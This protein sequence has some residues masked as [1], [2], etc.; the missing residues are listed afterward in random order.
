MSFYAD[1]STNV[2]LPLLEPSNNAQY[3]AFDDKDLMNVISNL[4]DAVT[5]PSDETS[6]ALYRWYVCQTNFEGYQYQTL[7]W[8]YGNGKPQNPTCVKADVKRVFV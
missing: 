4:N 5:P 8:V 1:P 2:A 7:A 3:V 6:T